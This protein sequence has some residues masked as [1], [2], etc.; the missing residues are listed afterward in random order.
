MRY[1]SF[2]LL[3]FKILCRKFDDG[4]LMFFIT[5]HFML[6]ASKHHRFPK[7]H[8]TNFFMPFWNFVAGL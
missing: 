7:N 4:S 8:S 3:I 2:L 6:S 1:Q 5:S